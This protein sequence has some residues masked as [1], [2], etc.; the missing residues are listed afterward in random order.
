MRVLFATWAWPT[1]FFPLVPLAWAFRTAGHEVVVASQ[2]S[3]LPTINGCG[4]TGVAL[5]SDRDIE[6]PV[7]ALLKQDP[8][9]HRPRKE[10]RTVRNYARMAEAMA[11]PLTELVRQWQPDLIVYEEATYAAPL[12]AA[13]A[14]IAAVRHLWGIDMM[15]FVR[16]SEP[17]SLHDLAERLGSGPVEGATA[18]TVDPCPPSLQVAANYPRVG[19]RHTPYNG[20]AAV[21]RALDRA[22]G[23]PRIC[24][25]YG[26]TLSQVGHA[27]FVLGRIIEALGPLEVEVVAAVNPTDRARLTDLPANVR[28]VQNQPLDAFL[29]GCALVVSHGGPGTVLSAAALG[30][31]QLCIP[32][33]ADQKLLADRLTECGAGAALSVAEATV[34][35][36]REAV[37]ELLADESAREAA[38]RL[39]RENAALPGPGEVVAQ[40]VS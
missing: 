26:R 36:I 5:G 14:G 20:S 11:P 10:S 24:V 25:T 30:V 38:S 19:M 7:D 21:A 8:D 29:S 27:V 37:R 15:S 3:L 6:A 39:R 40:L 9:D 22:P 4:F 17:I 23:R 16:W 2:P 12:V 32:Q 28:I 18:A 33:V 1:H 34:E 13:A 31:P 35:R